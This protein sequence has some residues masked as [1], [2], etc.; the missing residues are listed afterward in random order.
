MFEDN[1]SLDA[2]QAV[3]FR[4]LICDLVVCKTESRIFLM[5]L[6][7]VCMFQENEFQA[8]ISTDGHQ[9]HVLYLYGTM[10]ATS[11][12]VGV[13]NVRVR[14]HIII[15]LR[16]RTDRSEKT[17]NI[18]HYAVF[19]LDLTL[20]LPQTIIISFCKQHRSR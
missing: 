16:N 14:Y 13:D 5:R 3:Q 9:T 7:C 11:N 12:P 4:R 8:V 18:H 15:T 1:F 2:A 10:A 6:K 19:D 20:S 17:V